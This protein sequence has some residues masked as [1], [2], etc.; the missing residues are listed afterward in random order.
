MNKPSNKKI[1]YVPLVQ[2]HW[3]DVSLIYKQGIAEGNAT[4]ETT[5]PDW[6]TWNKTHRPDCR[7]VALIA[8]KIVGWAALAPV[9]GRCVYAGVS[10]ISVYI[11][12]DYRGTGIGNFLLASIICESER[13]GIWTLQAGIFPENVSSIRIHEKNGFR[14]VGIRERIGSMNSVWRDVILM[15]RR[16]NIAG[17]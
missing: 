10:E 2:A 4:F 12:E 1:V 9:S 6:E 13:K 16:S 5:C 7:F 3:P 14:K 17:I 15:E 11:H 8:D